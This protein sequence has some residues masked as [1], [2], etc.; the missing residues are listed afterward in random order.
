MSAEDAGEAKQGLFLGIVNNFRLVVLLTLVIVAGGIGVATNMICLKWPELRIPAAFVTVEYPGADPL[1][2]ETDVTN[3]LEKELRDLP[4]IDKLISNSQ[5]GMSNILV[6][7]YVEADM[8]KSMRKLRTKID[9]VKPKLPDRA[10]PPKIEQFEMSAM[11]ILY[12]VMTAPMPIEDL[13]RKAEDLKRRI[14]RVKGINK[15]NLSGQ[16]GESIEVE[17]HPHTLARLG[18]SAEEVTRVLRDSDLNYPFGSTYESNV[19]RMLKIPSRFRSAETL[20]KMPIAVRDARV[21]RLEE[22]ARVTD[23]VEP[24]EKIVRITTRDMPPQR[25]IVL[26]I[27]RSAGSDTLAASDTVKKL[28]RHYESKEPGLDIFFL[29]DEADDIRHDLGMMVSNGWQAMLLVFAVLLLAL[30]GREA[31]LSALAIPL[32]F[33]CTLIFVGLMGYS[34]NRLT[35]MALVI[36]LGLLVD[37]FILIMEGMHEALGAGKGPFGAVRETIAKYAI[38]SLSG[39]LTTI[40]AFLPLAIMPGIDGQFV[41][42]IPVTVA[43]TLACSY[44]ISI[45]ILPA[46]GRAVLRPA[47]PGAKPPLGDR[48]TERVA[49]RY[50]AWLGKWVVAS[51]LRSACAAGTA[52]AL[53]LGSC[54]L[55]GM[56]PWTLYP[57]TDAKYFNI[58]LTFPPG[59][60]LKDTDEVARKL[61]QDLANWPAVQKV[62]TFLGMNSPSGETDWDEMVRNKEA[63]HFV[64]FKVYLVPRSQREKDSMQI[65]QEVREALNARTD[66]LLDARIQFTEVYDGPQRFPPIEVRISGPDLDECGRLANVVVKE[67]YKKPGIVDIRTNQPDDSPALIL[68]PHLSR[69]IAAQGSVKMVGDELYQA[70]TGEK[71]ATYYSRE[72]DRPIRVRYDWGHPRGEFDFRRPRRASQLTNLRVQNLYGTWDDIKSFFDFRAETQPAGIFHYDAQRAIRVSAEAVGVDAAQ[73]LNELGAKLKTV[74]RK[75]G[76]E[77]QTIG[78]AAKKKEAFGNVMASMIVALLLILTV[79]VVQFKS[80]VQPFIILLTLPMSLIGVFTGFFLAGFTVSFPTMIGLVSLAGIVVNDAIVLIETANVNVREGKAVAEALVE[81]CRSRLRPIVI[82]TVTTVIGLLPLALSDPVWGGLCFAVIFGIT[83]ATFLTLFIVPALYRILTPA[84][85]EEAT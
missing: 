33:L 14:E 7:F 65:V 84:R 43:I 53:F 64:G 17:L 56:L 54:L 37:D 57:K 77:I 71:V 40:V 69:L 85:A 58:D 8:A 29:E 26:E 16:R 15:V 25:G 44:L 63:Q 79:L 27:I 3:K 22:V 2:V 31:V 76:H 81:A 42:I 5:P 41:R 68:K 4:G 28:L 74:D 9:A 51:R 78:A 34:L 62:V 67:L 46:F 21:I 52:L 20:R 61:E 24:E 55:Y 48:L 45:F 11:P 60:N 12:V 72:K 30:G 18:L 80:F 1:T 39:T 38:P 6:V 70:V 47:A 23:T 83:V 75:P 73:V 36:A 49:G 10:K 32:T 13:T 50:G 66:G 59:T 82:T 19:T 35:L